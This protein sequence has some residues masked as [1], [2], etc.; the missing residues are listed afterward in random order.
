MEETKEDKIVGKKSNTDKKPTYDNIVSTTILRIVDSIVL[1]V[2][3]MVCSLPI[4]TIGASTTAFYYA[5]HKSV[6]NRRGYA[7]QSFFHSFKSNF[8]QTLKVWLLML[9][10]YL[11][12]A[13]DY[14]MLQ[15]MLEENASAGTLS[16]IIL[17]IVMLVNLWGLYL[18]PYI[19]RFENTTKNILRNCML[20]ALMNLPASFLL[21][22]SFLACVALL[23]ACFTTISPL[24]ISCIP[25]LYIVVANQILERVFRKYLSPEDLEKLQ[26]IEENKE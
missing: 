2:L 19:A 13:F 15:A 4:I 7:W 6:R 10:L 18:F 8:K 1:S 16:N 21:L 25:A 12:L 26:Q 17:C 23:V 3:W 22:V 9:L 5:F 24:F 11:I 20:M 14:I